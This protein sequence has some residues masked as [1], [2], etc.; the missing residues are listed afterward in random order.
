L[1]PI[2]EQQPSEPIDHE[3]SVDGHLADT[4]SPSS[5]SNRIENE[6]TC[7]NVPNERLTLG[8]AVAWLVTSFQADRKALRRALLGALAALDAD[9]C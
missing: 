9:V 7:T 4:G 8:A 6:P 2:F 5:A 1:N 3:A